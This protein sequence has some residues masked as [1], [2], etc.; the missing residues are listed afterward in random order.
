MGRKAASTSG[1]LDR[2]LAREPGHV[3]RLAGRSR[4][5]QATRNA[6][7]HRDQS[8]DKGLSAG[9]AGSRTTNIPSPEVSDDFPDFAAVL[10]RELDAIEAY[11][12]ACLDEMLGG[13]D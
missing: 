3:R 11:L 8:L 12:G 5:R 7:G 1:V 2:K 4:P 13:M 6:R 9:R 10:D